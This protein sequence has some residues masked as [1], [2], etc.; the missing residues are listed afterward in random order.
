MRKMIRGH[1]CARTKFL[2]VNQGKMHRFHLRKMSPSE[3][4]CMS[5]AI[6]ATPHPSKERCTP[7]VVVRNWLQNKS[8]C[9]HDH[10]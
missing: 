8:D 2:M 5:V 6:I 7:V 10:I 1:I 3:M 9:Q 4:V